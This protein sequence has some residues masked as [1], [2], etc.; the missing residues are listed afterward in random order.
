[1]TED[2]ELPTDLEGVDRGLSSRLFLH[3][4]GMADEQSDK[5]Q[6]HLTG[7]GRQPLS[8][9]NILNRSRLTVNTPHLN[10]KEL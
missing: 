9:G 8:N 3:Y 6:V 4:S 1:M 5:R 2:E 7:Q 10:Y